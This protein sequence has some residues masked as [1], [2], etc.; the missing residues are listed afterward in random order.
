M[1]ERSGRQ[2]VTER[3]RPEW[4]GL[5]LLWIGTKGQEGSWRMRTPIVAADGRDFILGESE[6]A[7]RFYAASRSQ[8]ERSFWPR[9]GIGANTLTTPMYARHWLRVGHCSDSPGDTPA[10]GRAYLAGVPRASAVQQTTNR[11]RLRGW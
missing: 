8:R 5:I 3:Q 4:A 6:V 7:W 10:S 1:R 2:D 11:H 9:D